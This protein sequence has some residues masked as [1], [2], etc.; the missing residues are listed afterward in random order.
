MYGDLNLCFL[1]K[2]PAEMLIQAHSNLKNKYP[3]LRFLVYDGLRPRE[4]QK[5]LWK[6][7]DS[8]PVTQRAK[9]V[10][11]PNKG[12]IH[13]F[14]AAIDLTLANENGVP[15]DMGTRYDYF[16]DLAFVIY[17]DSLYN[18]GKLTSQQIEN[19]R[20]LREAMTQSGFSTINS[21]WWHFDAF[22]HNITKTKYSIIEKIGDYYQIN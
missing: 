19:R 14:G 1:R 16:G 3:H 7:L 5:Q 18:E 17:E 13:N 15:L 2:T 9:F 21:E 22:P 12:S 11:D 10:A 4:I 20:I 6:A 8:I